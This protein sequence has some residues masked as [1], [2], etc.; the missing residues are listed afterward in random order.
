ME[1]EANA[2]IKKSINKA[3]AKHLTEMREQ[4]KKYE[5]SRQREIETTKE[6]I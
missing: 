2:R 4:Y 3:V 1:K 6:G 5:E